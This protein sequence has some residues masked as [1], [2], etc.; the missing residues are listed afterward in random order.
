MSSKYIGNTPFQELLT[1]SIAGDETIKRA[2]EVLDGIFNKSVRAIPDL[3]FYARLSHDCGFVSPTSMLKSMERLSD[4]SDGLLELS[5]DVLDLLA[6]QFHVDGYDSAVDIRGKR[7][8]IQRSIQLHRKKGTPWAVE[9]A[10]NSIL[11]LPISVVEWYDYGGDPYH[12]R[13]RMDV[14]NNQYMDED[15]K[16]AISV[17]NEY[18]NVRSWLDGFSAYSKR[19]LNQNI[20]ICAGRFR[21]NGRTAIWQPHPKPIKVPNNVALTGTSRI[22]GK[23]SIFFARPKPIE[24]TNTVA[25][26]FFTKHE[27]IGIIWQNPPESVRGKNVLAT[28]QV[29]RIHT[30]QFLHQKTFDPVNFNENIA[31]S[32]YAKRSNHTCIWQNPPES[33]SDK[34]VLA[35]AQIQRIHTKQPLYQKVPEPVAFNKNIA[36]GAYVKRSNHTDIWQKHPGVIELKG[37]IALGSIGRISTKTYLFQDCHNDIQVKSKVFIGSSVGRVRSKSVYYQNTTL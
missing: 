21:I 4:L 22:C 19:E 36:I 35:V 32:I 14:S 17:I 16:N 9:M 29:Q 1:H 27:N 30:K 5:E 2:A 31:I 11:H 15:A 34:N 13:V 10:L 3:L 20:A 25:I 18:K 8:L 23:Q 6:W 26:G 33:V 28:A 12:F 24:L 7:E 37:G